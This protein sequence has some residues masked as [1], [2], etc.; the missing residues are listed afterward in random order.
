MMAG[1]D[2][3]EPLNDR[4]RAYKHY[5]AYSLA[6]VPILEMSTLAFPLLGNGKSIRDKMSQICD[7]VDLCYLRDDSCPGYCA[8]L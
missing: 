4:C 7:L 2:A 8:E 5:S 1:K 6:M 3:N